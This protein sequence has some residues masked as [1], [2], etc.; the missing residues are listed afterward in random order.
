VRDLSNALKSGRIMLWFPHRLDVWFSQ[1]SWYLCVNLVSKLYGSFFFFV[2]LEYFCP[3][4]HP[5][6]WTCFSSISS[7]NLGT[8]TSLIIYLQYWSE[9]MSLAPLISRI[10][11]RS[12]QNL[13]FW[14][15]LKSEEKSL[16]LRK[17]LFWELVSCAEVIL[18]SKFHSIWS[19]I[20][21]GSN[22]GR[23]KQILGENRVF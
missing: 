2:I 14:V 8:R 13:C 9:S 1:Y 3:I 12:P 21:Q 16:D 10:S 18:V 23:K 20:T 17:N 15:H 5:W 6:V 19:I 7:M 11:P 22:L 4:L